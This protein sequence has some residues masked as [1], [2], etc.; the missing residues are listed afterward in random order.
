MK[1]VGILG[2]IGSGKSFVAN[3][4][5]YPVFN[6]DK[7]VSLIYKNSYSC[8][9]NLKKE[10]PKLITKFPISKHKNFSQNCTYICSKKIKKILKK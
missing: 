2:D 3:K 7:I 1:I 6:A 5:G 8:F 4:F 9:K 10:F